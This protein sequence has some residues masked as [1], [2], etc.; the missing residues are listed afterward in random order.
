ML[1]ADFAVH[2]PVGYPACSRRFTATDGQ[3][4]P[5]VSSI[6]FD[7]TCLI[8]PSRFRMII[9]LFDSWVNSPSGQA[10][11]QV[12]VRHVK[13]LP[14]A[15]FRFHLAVDTLAFDYRIP[16]IT[17]PSGLSPFGNEAC[18]AHQRCR[19][20]GALFR[21]SFLAFCRIIR[22]YY[23]ISSP[24]GRHLCSL[25]INQNIQKPQ[26]ALALT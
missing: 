18:P 26:R 10:L 5:G 2:I 19:S 25:T 15:S 23:I 6:T 16:I 20:H 1:A 4:S 9:G 13:S 21:Y 7:L 14:S 24:A 8:Y 11:Y 12:S 3:R 22:H 17:A